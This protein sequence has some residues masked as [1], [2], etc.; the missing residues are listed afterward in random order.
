M[1]NYYTSLS[2]A[3]KAYNGN[4]AHVRFRL[5]GEMFARAFKIYNV[6]FHVINLTFKSYSIIVLTLNFAPVFVAIFSHSSICSGGI[7][8]TTD[9]VTS[10][11]L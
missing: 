7:M 2:W 1:K 5:G 11:P 8:L 10:N 4:F 3:D 6:I 9:I